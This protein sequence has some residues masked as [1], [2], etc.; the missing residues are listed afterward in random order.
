MKTTEAPATVV[1]S[2]SEQGPLALVP[3][4]NIEAFCETAETEAAIRRA[5]EDR[6][7]A[8]AT[9][10]TH[11]EGIMGAAKA[12]Q[13]EAT[14]PLLLVESRGPQAETLKQLEA[15]AE[16]CQ[17][18]TR[19][20]V[21][22]HV[23][24]VV[25]Y[26][27]LIRQGVSEYL[28]APVNQIQL[29]EAVASLFRNPQAA[30]IGRVFAFIGAKG[31]VGSS[32]IAQNCG[33]ALARNHDA[34]T[35]IADLDLPF[36]TAALNFNEDSAIPIAESLSQ[37]GR[38]DPLLLER[39]LT[40]LDGKLSLLGGLGGLDRDALIEPA[41]IE[42][43][44]TAM[45]VSVPFLVLDLPSTWAPWVKHALLHA[46]QVVIT[47]TPELA[48]LRNAKNLVELLTSA[49]PNDPPPRLVLNEMGI[50]KRPEIKAADFGKT[51]GVAVDACIPFDPRNF[52]AAQS[53]GRMMLQ[54]APA[55]KAAQAIAAF[56]ED[57]CPIT[58]PER[59]NRPRR[60][61]L[62]GWLMKPEKP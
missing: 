18:E 47:A 24:D 54:S 14:P 13:S 60:S 51:A 53:E 42:A 26:R 5:A 4:I 44:L 21:I 48:S 17:P 3:R 30:T 45:R 43:M 25:F 12:F 33:W 32:S 58:K 37:P 2:G 10:V 56:A 9:V 55:S 49:R 62:L 1:P 28:V 22:G 34:S 7:M 41:A 8:R 57:M 50:P 27:E 46:D 59:K 52:G 36:G 11:P 29:I 35:I 31:G 15:L 23:N 20:I 39:L 40:R 38:I 16:V 19:V 61:S 6:R